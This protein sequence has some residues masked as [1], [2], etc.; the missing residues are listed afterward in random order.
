MRKILVPVLLLLLLPLVAGGAPQLSVSTGSGQT[1]PTGSGSYALKIYNP[2]PARDTYEVDVSTPWKGSSTLS[3]SSVMV[4]PEE[5]ETVYLWI[6]APKT[7]SPG[8]YSFTVHLRSSNTGKTVQ[9]SGEI[10]VLSCRSVSVTPEKDMRTACRTEEAVYTF[11]VDNKGK[12]EE[13]YTLSSSYGTLS[14]NTLTL[15]PGE[16]EEVELTVSSGESTNRSI[17]FRAESTTSYASD[18]ASVRFVAE[19]CRGVSLSVAPDSAE[20]C[21]SDTVLVTASVT[22]TGSINDSYVLE[23]GGIKQNISLGAGNTTTVERRFTASAVEGSLHVTARSRTLSS[24]VDSGISDITTHRCYGL[25]LE[26]DIQDRP[27]ESVNRTVLDLTLLNNGTRSNNYTLKLDGPEWMDV[28]PA[29]LTLSPGGKAPAYVYLA[30]GFF[31][32]GSYTSVLVVSGQGVRETVEMNLTVRNGTVS[33]DIS[34]KETETPTGGLPQR[35][36]GIVP[37]VITALILLFGGYWF[38]RREGVPKISSTDT[39]EH[40]NSAGDFLDEN[41]NRVVKALRED[42]FS[43]SFLQALLKEEKQSKARDTVINQIRNELDREE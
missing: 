6:Q 3:S 34:G 36:A 38:F 37:L 2:G 22:N 8:D 11:E 12:V 29:N 35:A 15:Q 27:L 39:R 42:E 9:K 31:S 4:P 24:V 19:K 14:R 16:E 26:S 1:C 10:T 23:I 40:R 43:R 20:V 32:E 30:P 21:S 28:R 41:A 7:A 18:T 13:T 33:V 5:T 17:E 25:S